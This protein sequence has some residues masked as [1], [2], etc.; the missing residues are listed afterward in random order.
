MFDLTNEK[1]AQM[2]VS[3]IL[4]RLPEIKPKELR[5][6]YRHLL[7]FAETF[8]SFVES[9]NIQE[10]HEENFW[11]VI[12]AFAG[13]GFHFQQFLE[14]KSQE[15]RNKILL[16][17]W[18]SYYVLIWSPKSHLDEYLP[19]FCRALSASNRDVENKLVYVTDIAQGLMELGSSKSPDQK[20]LAGFFSD[21]REEIGS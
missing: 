2:L 1:M 10:R 19:Y 8:G 16:L 14:A 3:A 18:E 12:C 4:P 20:A 13:N 9:H 6:L 15:D 17:A 5:P 7:Q 21:L 11:R